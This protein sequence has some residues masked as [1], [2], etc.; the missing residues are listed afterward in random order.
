MVDQVVV[1]KIAYKITGF[2]DTKLTKDIILTG[3]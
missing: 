2:L 1:I 3:L